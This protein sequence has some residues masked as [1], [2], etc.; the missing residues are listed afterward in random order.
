MS[1]AKG[2]EIF[3]EQMFWSF[4]R[5]AWNHVDDKMFRVCHIQYKNEFVGISSDPYN[6]IMAY[7][8]HFQTSLKGECKI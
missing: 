3:E 1:T 4:F 5:F 6:Q 7:F 2:W 8:V